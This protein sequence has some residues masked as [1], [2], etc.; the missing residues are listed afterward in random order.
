MQR[1]RDVLKY[2]YEKLKRRVLDNDGSQ[3]AED[4]AEA[5]ALV[6]EFSEK[7]RELR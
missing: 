5:G 3:S 2:K 4:D 1:D 7:L 6:D